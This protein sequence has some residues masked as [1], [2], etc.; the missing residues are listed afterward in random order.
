MAAFAQTITMV[1]RSGKVMHT[2]K[3]LKNVLNEA[4][5]AYLERRAEIKDKR[6]VKE[7][8]E[9]Q[10]AIKAMSVADDET[11]S[12]TTRPEA[13]RNRSSQYYDPDRP[14]QHQRHLSGA[15]SHRSSVSGLT[16]IYSLAIAI[17]SYTFR[18]VQ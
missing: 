13:R 17:A 14:R 11:S 4:K 16:I 5:K 2:S 9:L 8:R 7:E 1:D 10:K 15:S 18:P 3:Q 6:K 12:S